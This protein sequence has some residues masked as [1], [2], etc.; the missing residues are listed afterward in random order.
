M[1]YILNQA[2]CLLHYATTSRIRFE[3]VPTL[4][5]E[6]TNDPHNDHSYSGNIQTLKKF[7][8]QIEDDIPVSKE[9]VIV[10]A[11]NSL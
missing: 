2:G 3:S 5:L 4:K 8:R 7:K 1:N 6:F 9:K 10:L 11:T